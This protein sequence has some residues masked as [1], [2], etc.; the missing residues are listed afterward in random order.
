MSKSLRSTTLHSCF[1]TSRFFSNG[2]TDIRASLSSSLSQ[3]LCWHTRW[4]HTQVMADHTIRN[5]STG[6]AP[7]K[8]STPLQKRPHFTGFQFLFRHV[9]G[10]LWTTRDSQGLHRRSGGLHPSDTTVTRQSTAQNKAL[11]QRAT[12][13]A[14]PRVAVHP[15]RATSCLLHV[16]QRTG[17]HS[18]P[19]SLQILPIT[20]QSADSFASSTS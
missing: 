16:P 17:D 14:T 4:P 10:P 15:G 7:C 12:R 8:R 1:H 6:A 5:C 13:T 9:R 2:V 19:H 11:R 18:S 3:L 20:S